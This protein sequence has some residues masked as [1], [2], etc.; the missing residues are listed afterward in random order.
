MEEQEKPDLD[1]LI[2]VVDPQTFPWRTKHNPHENIESNSLKRITCIGV[3]EYVPGKLRGEFMDELYRV[4]EE[5]GKATF[6]TAYFNSARGFQDFRYEWPPL[7]EQSFLYFNKGWRETNK[8]ETT[9]ICD[10]DFTYGYS[11][12]PETE[13]RNNDSKSFWVKRYSNCVEGLHITLTKKC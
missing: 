1:V 4:L 12:E 13:S 10:F 2:D 8:I 11:F 9:L 5:G 6:V 3:F 7:C